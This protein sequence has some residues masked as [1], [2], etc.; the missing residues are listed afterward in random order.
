MSYPCNP[1]TGALIS[2]TS[3]FLIFFLLAA[4][5]LPLRRWLVRVYFSANFRCFIIV[6][7]L[8]FTL[9]SSPYSARFSW[10]APVILLCAVFLVF[11]HAILCCRTLF[12]WIVT[13]QKH[14][15][16]MSHMFHL[17]YPFVVLH[18]LLASCLS[19]FCLIPSISIRMISI[20]MNRFVT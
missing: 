20:W 10:A 13:R 14:L 8:L 11:V 7:G 1:D 12:G 3:Y 15:N 4:R 9:P 2:C 18:S 6:F 5:L 19:L 17:R 16:I